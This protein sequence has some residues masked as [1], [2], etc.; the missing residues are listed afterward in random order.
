MTKRSSAS[1]ERSNGKFFRAAWGLIAGLFGALLFAAIGFELLQG[2]VGAVTLSKEH[3]VLPADWKAIMN[4]L[5]LAGFISIPLMFVIGPIVFLI[6]SLK[7]TTN[8]V[9]AT[10]KAGAIASIV[11]VVAV[12]LIQGGILVFAVPL[13]IAGVSVLLTCSYVFFGLK[14]SI[15]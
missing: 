9:S 7:T 11:G 2:I 4:G 1:G 6:S 10:D 13:W 5:F 8:E 12:G 14:G 3:F 15:D